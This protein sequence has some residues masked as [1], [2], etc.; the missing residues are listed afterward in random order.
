[1]KQPT[2]TGT[3]PARS[4]TPC[5]MGGSCCSHRAFWQ[6][7]LVWYALL[8]P[9]S[10]APSPRALETVSP[11][12]ARVVNWH[13]MH[14]RMWSTFGTPGTASP[15]NAT[16]VQWATRNRHAITGARAPQAAL[17][18]RS[19][20]AASDNASLS[21]AAGFMICCGQ[22]GVN[23]TGFFSGQNMSALADVQALGLGVQPLGSVSNLALMNGDWKGTGA[24]SKAVEWAQT[25]NLSGIV[26]DNEA[27]QSNC[28][29]TSHTTCHC[30][31]PW[32]QGITGDLPVRTP[33]L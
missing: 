13:T 15:P 16:N 6:Y 18:R 3:A 7:C 14:S 22:W 11:S 25:Y 28:T 8:A 33:Y 27:A 20:P 17:A 23:D 5:P 10:A 19:A 32:P 9:L 30:I 31:G 21:R 26:V 12:P 24:V 4:S 29:C 2:R 1:M